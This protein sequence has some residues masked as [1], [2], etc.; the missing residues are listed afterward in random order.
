MKTPE[1]IEVDNATKRVIFVTACR[2][3]T[4]GKLFVHIGKSHGNEIRIKPID[5][6]VV[7]VNEV[8]Y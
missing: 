2:S 7:E 8:E 6:A 4:S 3:K 5:Y 1:T